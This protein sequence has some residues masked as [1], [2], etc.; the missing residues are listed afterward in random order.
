MTLAYQIS[1][2]LSVLLFL[3]YGT[4]CLFADAMK[5]DFERFGLSRLRLLTGALEVL[6]AIG[7]VVGQF[8]PVL[9]VASAAGLTALMALGVMTR[10]R[11]RDPWWEA[12]PAAILMCVN[13]FIA[14]HALSIVMAAV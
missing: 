4:A 9:I 1:T 10:V 2:V 6:G 5:T 3:Y 11:V 12:L 7:L 13:G 14:W 8:A